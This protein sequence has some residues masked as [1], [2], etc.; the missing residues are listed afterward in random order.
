MWEDSTEIYGTLTFAQ[1]HCAATHKI[2]QS[3]SHT[4]FQ[5]SGTFISLI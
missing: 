3:D 4:R 2:A 5:A 1:S